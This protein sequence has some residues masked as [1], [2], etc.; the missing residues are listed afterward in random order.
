MVVGDT[1]STTKSSTNL[2]R[3]AV[4]HER[5]E[6]HERGRQERDRPG[7]QRGAGLLPYH[8]NPFRVFRVFRGS[9]GVNQETLQAFER[10]KNHGGCLSRGDRTSS[11][12]TRSSWRS[13]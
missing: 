3:K 2:E 8:L 4:N 13:K 1:A 7:D 6:T 9:L 5:H 11:C 10:G 12:S